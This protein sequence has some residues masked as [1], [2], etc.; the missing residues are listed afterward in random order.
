M[1]KRVVF[2]SK[3]LPWLLLAPQLAVTLVF[4]FWP[5]GQALW[6]STQLQDAFGLQSEFVGLENFTRLFRQPEYLRSFHVTA[7]FSA[8]VA[9]IG[10]TL[11]LLLAV[12]ADQAIRGAR[13]YRTLLIW[14]YAVAPVVAGV[15]WLFLFAPSLGVIAVWLQ[16]LGIGWNPLLDGN[17][18]LILVTVAAVWKQVSYNFLFF[19]AGLQAIPRSLIEAASLDG[20][21]PARRFWTIIFPLLS[22]TTFF[23]LVV[24]I[25]YAFFD[26]FAVIDATTSGGPGGATAILV[27]K[28]YQ[29]GFRSMDLGSSSAQS[30]ILMFIVVVLTVF[31]FRYIDR[32]VQY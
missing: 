24:N 12:K 28:V 1:E 15:L 18:A 23:L 8:L 30:V 17:H 11:S 4:F 3:T 22:P 27:Y 6:Q 26:T 10:L 21:G 13:V 9:G 29:D 25:I 32:K 14:P 20:A 31:Q 7:I 19:L 2:G 5:A 16:D